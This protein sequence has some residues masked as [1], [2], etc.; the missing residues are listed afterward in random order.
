M[1][2]LLLITG[3]LYW[4][5]L[6]SGQQAQRDHV[7]VQTQLR[8]A[9]VSQALSVQAG[10]MFSGLDYALRNLVEEFQARD[11]NSFQRAVDTVLASHPQGAILQIA[12]ADRKGDLIYSSLA[13]HGVP[14]TG[15]TVHDREYFQEH[16]QQKIAGMHIG[17]PIKGRI[18]N[19]WAVPLTRTLTRN[20]EFLGVMVLSLSPDYIAQFFRGIFNSPT[21]VIFLVRSDGAYLARSL[22]QEKVLGRNAPITQE[23]FQN[24]PLQTGTYDIQ[25]PVDGM[26][27][28]YAWTR[29][30][31]FPVVVTTGLDKQAIFAPLEA[32]LE[33][34]LLSN[35]I[36]TTGIMLGALVLG[37]LALQH[38]RGLQSIDQGKARLRLL[39]EQVPG[40][41]FQL[42]LSPDKKHDLIYASPGLYSIHCMDIPT[43]TTNNNTTDNNT[44]NNKNYYN[45]KSTQIMVHVPAVDKRALIRSMR[46]A[47]HTLQPWS[48]KYRVQCPDG[49]KRW[50]H[51]HAQPQA[52][53]DGSILW[54]GY[55]R[56]VTED[57]YLQ[58]SLQRSEE[59]LRLTVSA[60][61]DGLWQWNF[62]EN[63]MDWD[64]RCWNML[65]YPDQAHTMHIDDFNEIIHPLDRARMLSH[66][67][68]HIERGETFYA[69][70]RVRT[71][72]GSW[73]WIESRGQITSRDSA[74]QP[75]RMMG[76]HTDIQK[77]KEQSQLVVALLD[78][79]SALIVVATPDRKF[80]HLNA[81]AKEA[82]ARGANE[83]LEGQSLRIVHKDQAHFEAFTSLY[84]ELRRDG[85]ARTEWALRTADGSVRWYDVQGA[86]LDPEDPHGNII[87]TMV[88]TDDR[89]QAEKALRQAQERLRA[90]IKQFPGGVLL[91]D[92]SEETVLAANES[93]CLLLNLASTPEA[94]SGQPWAT[95]EAALPTDLIK[96]LR[97][98]DPVL[99][100]QCGV[101]Q[102][103]QVLG[104]SE[105]TPCNTSASN[106]PNDAAMVYQPRTVGSVESGRVL[107]IEH[108]AL[109]HNHL[110][111]GHFWLVRNVTA[112]KL[113][114]TRLERL[115]STDSL[116][117]LANRRAFMA[118][119]ELEL[120]EIRAGTRAPGTLVM[121][122]IDFFKK[123]NDT[124]GHAA[125]D[126]V[127]QHLAATVAHELRRNDL[128]GRLGG[129]EF[130]VLLS[131][132]GSEGGLM[133]AERLREA[134]AASRAEVQD[135]G[136]IPYTISLGVYSLQ[137]DDLS[138]DECLACADAAMYQSKRNGRNRTTM[139]H[140]GMEIA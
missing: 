49:Q 126:Q 98:C 53:A 68:A 44:K 46:I 112:R 87:W 113:R 139:W 32:N 76:T 99:C 40:G 80:L 43:D 1:G 41:L 124:Y 38:Q 59:R 50:L 31:E 22:E 30:P 17:Q 103:P 84:V 125:G 83:Q 106:A 70:F 79:A 52:Q 15:F 90:I 128:A 127:I 93:L 28:F 58:E 131:G 56:D 33:A 117:H 77:R 69:E 119:L 74:G 19:Q 111:L 64:G 6:L 29:V 21:D 122:D 60:V 7:Q 88:D 55:V 81:R 37:W 36:G 118:R 62:Q 13:R 121:M 130:A 134:V 101:D 65:G 95:L 97:A 39:A 3:M 24:P 35:L 123:V 26:A 114:E 2:L 63:Q 61:G 138:P 92:A 78:H 91:T 75:L 116:T 108:I 18:S 23:F 25:S 20:G 71:A 11:S 136:H 102:C 85:V 94:L 72:S 109:Q 133:H 135:M 54:H 10:T 14:H 42:C 96:A 137:H 48:C 45:N 57:Q 73:R 16:A 66:T 110:A 129:E 120:E 115:A 47:A 132:A 34:N 8:A 140:E 51:G 89:H 12:V 4:H 82:F 67:L 5:A 100:A 107:Q 105:S 9:Q 27:R 104:V 86:L